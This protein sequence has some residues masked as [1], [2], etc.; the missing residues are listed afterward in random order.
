MK[1]VL[2]CGGEGIKLHQL[3]EK[4]PKPMVPIGNRPLIWHVMKY[5]AHFGHKDFILCLGIRGDAIKDYFIKYKEYISND[6]V[7]K[8]SK[9]DLFERDIYDWNITFVDTGIE[10]S[11]SERLMKVSKYLDGEEMF[12]VNYSDGLTDLYLPD[13]IDQFTTSGKIAGHL[14]TRPNK[15]LY[16]TSIFPQRDGYISRV[17]AIKKLDD[18]YVNAGYY[19]FRKE[20]F[21]HIE[22]EGDL[23]DETLTRLAALSQLVA[24]P[25]SGMFIKID[26][27][28]E[29]QILDDMHDRG[30]TPWQVWRACIEQPEKSQ[31]LDD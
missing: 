28:K 1:V 26:T 10:S 17:T 14:V 21:Q 22:P 20:I 2:F 18:V 12:L 31:V 13:M 8:G 7:L 30:D 3:D 16:V 23:A 19:I 27:F 5:Y 25:Y 29:K 15:S 6:F 11:V 24:Y 9:I 4:M